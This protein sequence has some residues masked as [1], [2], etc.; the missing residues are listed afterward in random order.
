MPKK[1][2]F[3]G[4][5][6][7]NKKSSS[8]VTINHES[9]T[10][11][12][13]EGHS[14]AFRNN[15]ECIIADVY[16]LISQEKQPA[17]IIAEQKHCQS[18]AGTLKLLQLSV[19]LLAMK[20]IKKTDISLARKAQ[21]V[22]TSYERLSDVVGAKPSIDFK[23]IIYTDGVRQER[24][25]APL[26][27]KRIFC[28]DS[29]SSLQHVKNRYAV[30]SDVTLSFDIA[31]TRALTAA[32]LAVC[33]KKTG[34]SGQY[35]GDGDKTSL[36]SNIANQVSALKNKLAVLLSSAPSSTPPSGESMTKTAP[37]RPSDS[38][39]TR[40]AKMELLGML[41]MGGGAFAGDAG[42]SL[43]ATR[44]IDGRRGEDVGA[45][46][47]GEC[48]MGASV[49]ELSKEV[50]LRVQAGR[51]LVDHFMMKKKEKRRDSDGSGA[52]A[53][54][55][56]RADKQSV[57]SGAEETEEGDDEWGCLP[58]S[59]RDEISDSTITATGWRPN[60][61]C[62]DDEAWGGPYGKCC[63]HNEVV[64]HFLRP[65]APLEVVNTHVCSSVSPA[66]GNFL[67][68]QKSPK[69]CKGEERKG[70][71]GCLE[72][73][74]AQCRWKRTSLTAWDNASFHFISRDGSHRAFPKA[75]LLRLSV[76][77]LQILMP[78]LRRLTIDTNGQLSPD[79]L[80]QLLLTY[81]E[82]GL[83]IGLGNVLLNAINSGLDRQI[84]NRVSSFLLTGTSSQWK[85]C[86]DEVVSIRTSLWKV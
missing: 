53:R 52:P 30:S 74:R 46:W 45:P 84:T 43:A 72:F 51:A 29:M 57:S 77:T 75:A 27:A 71:D 56:R 16:Y 35:C 18:I 40:R 15:G 83:C 21:V 62:R 1:K 39:K 31:K 20:S 49:D 24:L 65:F 60:P 42:R 34:N 3:I 80:V 73:L 10:L 47:R 78:N 12:K 48:R 76:P 86:H 14:W 82:I 32:K 37:A 5:L 54:K 4:S 63:A 13:C 38:K 70:Y 67:P 61:H 55:K 69:G 8:F 22:I 19:A 11:P 41:D 28:A 6:G 64:M 79:E 66:P 58:R 44:W 59:I 68:V 2:A 81:M 50:M 17:L 9:I 85:T 25:T 36:D 7:S 23:T 33:M 26:S